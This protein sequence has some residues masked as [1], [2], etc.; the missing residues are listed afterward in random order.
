MSN[1]LSPGTVIGN[2]FLIEATAAS[3]GMGTI[4]R[5]RDLHTEAL[6]ALKVLHQSGGQAEDLARFAQ[7]ASVLSSLRHPAIVNYVAHGQTQS[8]QHYLAMDWLE[9]EDLAQRLA[10]QPLT[11]GES[12]TLARR[13]AEALVAA[14]GRGIL[15]RD[16][17]I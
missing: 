13:A 17:C 16:F 9:G 7:E 8:G 4:F 12:L 2:R 14:H 15:H 5:A 6:V 10:R 11:V 3:G 1:T